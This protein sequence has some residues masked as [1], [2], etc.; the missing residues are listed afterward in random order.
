MGGHALEILKAVLQNGILL[1]PFA[2]QLALRTHDTGIDGDAA[3]ART[4]F[5]FLTAHASVATKRVLELGPG[6]ALEV[7]ELAR[8][9][10]AKPAAADIVAHLAP[11]QARERGVDYRIY[12]GEHLPW[13]G[14]SFDVVFAHY[15]L[16]HMRAPASV[17]LEIARVLAPGGRLVCRVDLRDHYHMFEPG[18]QFHCLRHPAWLWRLMTW[19]RGSYV[20]RLRCPAWLALFDVAGLRVVHL[21]RHREPALLEAN[22]GHHYLRALADDELATYRFD[23]VVERPA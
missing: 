18:R 23:A 19:N 8:D 14:A 3:Q 9:A 1:V 20:N 5:D 15:A 12:D 6:R 4:A 10:G 17:V 11:T 2:R 22:R 21:E 13:P 7:M 16:Q